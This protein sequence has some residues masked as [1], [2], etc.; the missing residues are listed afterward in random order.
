MLTFDNFAEYCQ[1]LYYTDVIFA[2]GR[3]VIGSLHLYFNNGLPFPDIEGRKS[4]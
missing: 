3:T 1:Q 2:D 4:P